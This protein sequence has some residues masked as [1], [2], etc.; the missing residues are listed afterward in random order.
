MHETCT[1]EWR[2]GRFS[3]PQFYEVVQN[4]NVSTAFMLQVLCVSNLNTVGKNNVIQQEK[5]ASLM[6]PPQ[7]QH[8][9]QYEAPCS[10]KILILWWLFYKAQSPSLGDEH[11]SNQNQSDTTGSLVFMNSIG[12]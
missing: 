4:I 6:P 5:A 10:W 1:T 2:M 12:K 9:K 8:Y 7:S 11:L 3:L